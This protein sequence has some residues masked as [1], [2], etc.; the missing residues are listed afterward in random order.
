MVV[1]GRKIFIATKAFHDNS[2]FIRTTA[3]HV[4]PI[5]MMPQLTDP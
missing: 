4:I 1:G 5:N 2:L 3:K